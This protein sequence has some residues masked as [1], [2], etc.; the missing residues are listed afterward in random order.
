LLAADDNG[1][2]DPFIRVYTLG[3]QKFSAVCQKSL[4]PIFNERIEFQMAFDNVEDAP[5]LIIT[6]WDYDGKSGDFMGGCI[7]HLKE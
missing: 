2:A 6:V 1:L 5:P 3:A 4:N 7:I